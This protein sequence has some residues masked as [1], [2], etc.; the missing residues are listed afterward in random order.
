M[1]A[2]GV[3]GILQGGVYGHSN[4]FFAKQLKIGTK[5]TYAGLLRG[6]GFAACR[7]MLSQGIPYMFAGT[8]EATVMDPLYDTSKNPGN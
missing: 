3:V 4:I 1:I 8:V 7:D 6:W 2:F 5:V